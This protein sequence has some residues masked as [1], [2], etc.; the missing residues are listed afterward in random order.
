ME[1]GTNGALFQIKKPPADAE[2]EMENQIGRFYRASGAAVACVSDTGT[3][4]ALS[5]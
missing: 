2:G 3:D 1:E 4:F 5:F